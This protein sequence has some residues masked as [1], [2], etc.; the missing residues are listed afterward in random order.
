MI[1]QSLVKNLGET[2]SQCK[3]LRCPVAYALPTYISSCEQ[4]PAVWPS[5]RAANMEEDQVCT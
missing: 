1:Q 4:C 5:M 2:C 3:I